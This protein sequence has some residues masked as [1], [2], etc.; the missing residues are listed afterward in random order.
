LVRPL[1]EN[2]TNVETLINLCILMLREVE[3]QMSTARDLLQ[4]EID[5]L[6][7]ETLA[8]LPDMGIQLPI[9]PDEVGVRR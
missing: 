9:T 2:R 6:T 3:Q 8:A 7:P 1:F 5:S 4:Q